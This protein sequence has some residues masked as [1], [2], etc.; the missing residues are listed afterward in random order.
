MDILEVIAVELPCNACGDRYEVTLKQILLSQQMLHD[1]CPIPAHYTTE[2]PPL[3]YAD[4]A[5]RELI[6]GLNRT[7]LELEA[8]VGRVGARLL[9]RGGQKKS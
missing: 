5:D 2:C 3:H 1:G 4:L 7:W 6:E 9:L 8:R